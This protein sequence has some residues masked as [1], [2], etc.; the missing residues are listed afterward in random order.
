MSGISIIH[1]SQIDAA[2]AAFTPTREEM[3]YAAEVLQA[4]E[5]ARARGD[6]AIALRGQLL[7][8]PIVDRARQTVALGKLL[9]VAG[10]G[11]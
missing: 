5:A 1:P 2:N 11:G 10:S 8:Y 4:F 7:D 9:G 3:E 6:G